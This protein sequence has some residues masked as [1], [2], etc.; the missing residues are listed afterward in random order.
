MW[1]CLILITTMGCMSSPSSSSDH[2]TPFS[3]DEHNYSGGKWSP[4]GRWFAAS[5]F[6]KE[7]I[8]LFSSNGQAVS[9]LAGCDLPGLGTN[10][11]WL[12]DG[13]ISCF[14]GDTPTTRRLKIV[15][16]DQ[17][18]YAKTSTQITLPLTPGVFV[19]DLGWSPHHFWL[20]TLADSQP[21]EISPT[22]YLTDLEG[23]NLISP[24]SIKG[25][26][27]AWSP[28]G[29]TL[30][31]V[32]SNGDVALLK[33]KQTASGTL[34][35]TKIRQLAAGTPVDEK[36]AWS[37]SGRWLVCHHRTYESE[38]YLFLLAT[39]GLGKHVKLTSSI[40]DGHLGDPA[41]SPDGKQLIVSRVSD[42][43]LMSLDIA[44]VLK[45]KGVEP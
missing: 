21:G 35:V 10:I 44:A 18:G 28:D 23:H 27:L 31:L 7:I 12:P 32:L 3:H 6:P 43:A 22:L 38:D 29:T 30:A 13:H 4:D 33:A 2:L 1:M 40:T 37:P 34:E 36:V 14:T 39:D 42:G 9:T 15:E 16:L 25:E 26:Q 20:A 24:L 41:W 8:Q 17:Q 45:A 19:N 11:A 5:I